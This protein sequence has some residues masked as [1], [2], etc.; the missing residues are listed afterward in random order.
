MDILNFISW[1]KG[2]RIV[3]SVNASQTLLPVGLKDPKRDDGYLAG[4]ISV[5]DFASA[6]TPTFTNGNIKFG[7]SA[8]ASVTSGWNNIALGDNSLETITTG[9]VNIAIGKSALRNTTTADQNVGIGS[10]ALLDN[11]TG[12]QNIAIGNSALLK[13]TS[14]ENNVAIGVVSMLFNTTGINNTAIGPFTLFDI[15]TGRDNVAVGL[16]ALGGVT[17][18]SYN[19][20]V[21]FE[22]Y[23]GNYSSCVLLGRRAAAT[24]NNQFS[25]GSPGD[26]AGAVVSETNTSTQVWNVR[27]NGV[28]RKILLA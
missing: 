28:A 10:S 2:S 19:T 20:G 21:G 22:T 7:D 15:T 9:S 3:T 23:A 1:I 17:T 18:G 11:T 27:I 13:N 4:A 12:S 6:I 16:G 14:G 24:G 5:L 26:P 8:L 25:V